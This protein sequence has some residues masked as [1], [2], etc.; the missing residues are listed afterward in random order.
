MANFEIA[1][2]VVMGM[3]IGAGPDYTNDPDDPG[4]ETKYGVTETMARNMGYKGEMKDL[5]WEFAKR[6][7][8]AAFWDYLKLD[9]VQDQD[10]AT[11]LFDISVNISPVTAI[12]YL[13]RT[14][15]VLNRNE[16]DWPDI[17]VDGVIG[18]ITLGVMNQASSMSEMKKRNILKSL[19]VLQ[20]Y[21]YFHKSELSPSRK[22]KFLNGWLNK[23]VSI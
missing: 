18:K 17:V 4:G 7:Y 20:G 21:F 8:K 11:E 13:Q 2:G 19:N 16:M 23:R 10:I 22:E 12:M 15:N 6:V 5:P 14:L 9:E 3:E 1:L